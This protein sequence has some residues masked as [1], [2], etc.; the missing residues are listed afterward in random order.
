LPAGCFLNVNVPCRPREEITGV[1]VTRLGRR[2]YHDQL[3]MRQDPRG[4]P[5]YWIG[6]QPPGGHM[7]EGTD[8]WAV[9]QGYVSVTPVHLDMTAHGLL[10]ELEGWDLE[11]V[12]PRSPTGV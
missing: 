3:V 6:G 11:V 4:R 8:I 7:D 9:A 5:Y 2:L 12:L 1:I 10:A